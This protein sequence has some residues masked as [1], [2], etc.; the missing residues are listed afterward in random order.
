MASIY[1]TDETVVI[2]GY[3]KTSDGK[4]AKTSDGKYVVCFGSI[5]YTT[6]VTP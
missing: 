4:Y 1:T 5:L 6:D 2:R 3:V